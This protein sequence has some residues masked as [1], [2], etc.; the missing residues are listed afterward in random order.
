MSKTY[1]LVSCARTSFQG[2]GNLGIWKL[3]SDKSGNLGQSGDL[4]KYGGYVYESGSLGRSSLREV[5]LRGIFI[6]K[7]IS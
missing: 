6:T 7:Y 3:K 5:G 4:G 2:I 1:V